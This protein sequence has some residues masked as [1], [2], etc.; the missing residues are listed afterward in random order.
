M[1]VSFLTLTIMAGS[2]SR[3]FTFAPDITKVT[4]NSIITNKIPPPK[5]KP[6]LLLVKLMHQRGLYMLA[7]SPVH[8][9]AACPS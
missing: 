6:P 9:A 1:L 4:I 3:A 7:P 2:L 5:P 8:K